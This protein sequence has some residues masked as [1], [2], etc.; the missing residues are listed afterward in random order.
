MHCKYGSVCFLVVWLL[1]VS[2]HCT[3]MLAVSETIFP[4]SLLMK[5]FNGCTLTWLVL[6]E[7]TRSVQQQ[8]LALLL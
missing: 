3:F 5:R 4:Y 2:F 7:M 1:V 6:C 8:D